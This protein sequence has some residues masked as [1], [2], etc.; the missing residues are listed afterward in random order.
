M[1]RLRT[2][3]VVQKQELRT[4]RITVR[5]GERLKDHV[6]RCWLVSLPAASFEH[7]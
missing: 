6:R 7:A 1:Q 3:L 4:G 2:L 5:L